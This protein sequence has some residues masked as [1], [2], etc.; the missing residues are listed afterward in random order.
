MRY[1]YYY[2]FCRIVN[3]FLPGYSQIAKVYVGYRFQCYGAI[4]FFVLSVIIFKFLIK[5]GLELVY[6]RLSSVNIDT[7][8]K[9][10]WVIGIF[11]AFGSGYFAFLFFFLPFILPIFLIILFVKLVIRR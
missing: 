8:D 1:Y 10:S 3:E 4:I 2:D 7:L 5:I 11:I 9:L 6:G